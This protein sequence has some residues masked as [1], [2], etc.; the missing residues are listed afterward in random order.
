MRGT[1]GRE[2]GSVL[3]MVTVSLTVLFAMLGLAIDLGWMYFV[4]RSAQAAADA[5][6]LAAAIEALAY[7]GQ[8]GEFDCGDHASC[9]AAAPCS[10]IPV[11]DPVSNVDYGCEYSS[12]NGF[13]HEGRNG[14]QSVHFAAGS[15]PEPPTVPGVVVNYWATATVAERVPASFSAIL[16][17]TFGI[18]AAR[19]TAAVVDARVTGS[20]IL[21]NREDDC[22]PMDNN[23]SACGINLLVQSNDNGDHYAVE[24]HAGIV[25]ASAANGGTGGR[26][27]G[28]SRGGGT[29]SAPYTYIRGQGDVYLQGSSDWTARPVNGQPE[30]PVFLDP[31]RGKGQPPAP[32]GLRDIPVP[33]GLL[34]GGATPDKALVLPPG[35]YYATEGDS[36]VASGQPLQ[37][38]GHV[39]FTNEGTGF[40]EFVFFGGVTNQNAGTV[41][42]LA[43]GAYFFAG[44]LPKANGDPN[45]LFRFEKNMTLQDQTASFGANT[46]AGELMVFT[47][48]NYPG[49]EVPAPVRQL[50]R[51]LPH[52]PT[53]FSAGA[54]DNSVVNLH[55]LN[56]ASP[57]LPA[58]WKPFAPAVI[59]QDQAN[60]VVKYDAMGRI[61]T[62]CGNPNGCPNLALANPK[63]TRLFL[64]ASPNTHLY[65]VVYQ[66]RGAWT[67]MY[68]GGAYSGPLQLIAGAVTVQGNSQLTLINIDNPLRRR[69]VALVE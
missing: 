6:A 51:S 3:I 50:D 27:A 24:A 44:V 56:S 45:A 26:Y 57:D 69:V 39:R 23:Q 35:N 8:N 15:D 5:G 38:S 12:R 33:G 65:G 68:G 54:T 7:V 17:R 67:D 22:L 14:R 48:T 66:P 58:A 37:F 43:P 40:G 32:R 64:R 13:R 53:G 49:L 20:L 41:V 62:S 59:W 63:S 25:L 16:G 29:V 60:S 61:D 11:L 55:G 52:G 1:S 9:H 47:D 42:T 2:K 18:S 30:G 21:L 4:K 46:D 36:P 19:A 10:T 28:E 31:M 34:A